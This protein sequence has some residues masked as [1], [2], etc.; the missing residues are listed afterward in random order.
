MPGWQKQSGGQSIP[1]HSYATRLQSQAV[2]S[3]CSGVSYGQCSGTSVEY[4]LASE[5]VA[6]GEPRYHQSADKQPKYTRQPRQV[7]ERWKEQ[8]KEPLGSQHCMSGERRSE[9]TVVALLLDI[10]IVQHSTVPFQA[11]M[12]D[13][14]VVYPLVSSPKKRIQK[15][16]WKIWLV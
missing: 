16:Y 11:D 8:V 13:K 2:S 4:R 10:N 15:K 7:K 14:A 6:E 3:V 1:S 5:K 12:A 9:F